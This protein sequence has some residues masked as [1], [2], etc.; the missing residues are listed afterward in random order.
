[1]KKIAVLGSGNGGCATAFDCAAAGFETALFDFELFPAQIEAV[2]NAG[3]IHAEG[4]L[5]GF[6][7]V[8]YAGHDIAQAIDR[9][10]LIYAVGPAY[11]TEPF[12]TACKEYIRPG[13]KVVVCPGSCGG[14]L[15]FKKALGLK[16]LDESVLVGETST[17]PYAVRL[18]APGR[19]RVFLRLRGG[20][21]LSALPGRRT[22][23]ILADVRRVYDFI[24]PA[25][26]VLQTMLQNANPVIHPA[27][28]LL[29]AARIE[30]TKGDFCFYEDGVTPAVGRVMKGVDDERIALGRRLGI[31]I[32]DDPRTG[33]L[34]GYMREPTYDK[35]YSEA[36]GFRGIKAQAELDYRY[37]NED[38][39]YGLVFLS[40][41]GRMIDVPTPTIDALIQIISVAMERDYRREGARTPHALGLNGADAAALVET[42]E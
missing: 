3:G 23:D 6:A 5:D 42:V 32:L 14:A 1:M 22:G 10:E 16:P 37:W 17:L 40:E 41:L 2:K 28:T 12:A 36:P 29:N 21:W 25:K 18:T 35:G 24:Q 26:N 39:G 13:Q 11:S 27:V 34:Q 4:D 31:E 30:Q 38:V 19:I 7:P 8:A 9:A 20:L 33:V 15:V